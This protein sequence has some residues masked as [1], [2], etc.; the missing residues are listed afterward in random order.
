LRRPAQG[1]RNDGDEEHGQALDRPHTDPLALPR[2]WARKR[3]G[4]T[5]RTV[6][7]TGSGRHRVPAAS[8]ERRGPRPRPTQPVLWPTAASDQHAAAWRWA[9]AL[10]TQARNPF[11]PNGK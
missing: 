8:D 2:A 7:M 6:A 4:R 11:T 3:R 10:P 5:R 1:Q 9:G